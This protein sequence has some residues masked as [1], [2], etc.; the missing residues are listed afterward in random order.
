MSLKGILD[1]S[2]W[3]M[4]HKNAILVYVPLS[5]A[6]ILI[7]IQFVLIEMARIE[8]DQNANSRKVIKLSN[9]VG[10]LFFESTYL[11]SGYVLTKSERVGERFD[12]V[13][14]QLPAKQREL[15]EQVRGNKE[16]LEEVKR[17]QLI[18]NR[19]VTLLDALRHSR[20]EGSDPADVIKVMGTRAHLVSL[21][22]QF[23]Q[24]Q[25]VAGEKLK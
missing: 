7:V 2:N 16:Q 14:A 3:K 11:I 24:E 18:V 12:A 9:D 20:D 25:Q 15:S 4:A 13:V 22:K 21:L 17:M 23:M 8:V 5:L 10:A 6:L 1:Q 19:G